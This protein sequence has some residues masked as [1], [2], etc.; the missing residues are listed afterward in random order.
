[1]NRLARLL[2]IERYGRL[3]YWLSQGLAWE[4]E[5][6]VCKDVYCFPFRTGFVSKKEHK[7]WPTRLTAVMK[8]RGE[9]PVTVDELVG[10]TR[11]TWNEERAMLSWGAAAMLAKHYD[12]ELPRVL[13]AYAKLRAEE[14][15][16]TNPDGSWQWIPD[17]EI[18]A[19]KEKEI[20][21]RELGVDFAAEL[22]RFARKPKG[23]RR[24][25]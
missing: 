11:N 2:F 22:T 23:Y 16:E 10:W 13:A 5:L 19:E 14:G 24:P 25:R 3:P 7:T 18:S 1:V 21:D 9:R 4:L 8:A 20:L 15:R 12:G 17:Y 6:R